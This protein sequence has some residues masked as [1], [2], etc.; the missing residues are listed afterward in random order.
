MLV[1]DANQQEVRLA[2]A[3]SGDKVL[4]QQLAAGEDLHQVTADLFG[5]DR[6]KGKSINLALNYGMSAYGLEN[7]LGLTEE[8]ADAGIAAR[9]SKYKVQAAWQDGIVRKAQKNLKVRSLSG[10]PIWINPYLQH[11]GWRRNAMNGP[12]QG[13]AADHTKLAFV[14]MHQICADEGIPFRTN[15]VVHDEMAVDV[16]AGLMVKYRQAM[17]DAWYEAGKTLAPGVELPI[18]MASGANWGCK[19]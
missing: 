11:D 10:R 3:L 16:P 14:N 15:L 5:V 17:N 6:D 13:S 12:V 7:R 2:A 18:E 4:L 8:Q 19:K 9:R 1:S